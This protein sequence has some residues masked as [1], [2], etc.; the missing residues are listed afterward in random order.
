MSLPKALCIFLCLTLVSIVYKSQLEYKF[1]Q[2][3]PT[4]YYSI[5][6]PKVTPH[7]NLKDGIM[8]VAFSRKLGSVSRLSD[9][10]KTHY[11]VPQF[12]SDVELNPGPRTPKYPCQI[13]SRA[14][15]WKQGGLLVTT[16]N[17]GTMLTA[18]ICPLQSTCRSTMFLGTV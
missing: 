8:V 15:K 5:V 7:E 9:E 13:C 4:V 2:E 18:C 11:F 14:V 6:R 12:T 16:V 3:H 1:I 10:K 17:N